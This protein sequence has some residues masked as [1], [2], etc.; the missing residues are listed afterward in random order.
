M[1]LPPEQINIKRRRVEEPVETLCKKPHSRL[2]SEGLRD[3]LVF[4]T[5]IKLQL[6]SLNSIR[7]NVDLLTLSSKEFWRVTLPATTHLG[8]LLQ[9]Q[10][11]SGLSAPLDQ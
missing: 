1:S 11:P 6:S 7:Q 3:H 2:A 10:L 5:N 8:P 9:S 4:E